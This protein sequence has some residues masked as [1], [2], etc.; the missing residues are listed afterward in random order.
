M[1][2]TPFWQAQRP[3]NPHGRLDAPY[4]RFDSDG[5]EPFFSHPIS[6]QAA[7]DPIRGSRHPW[8]IPDRPL[9][10]S[11]FPDYQ[12]APAPVETLWFDAFPARS[13]NPRFQGPF[14]GPRVLD[15]RIRDQIKR[16]KGKY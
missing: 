9:G 3:V 6:F 4:P 15:K 16:R 13:V 7:V 10:F 14:R 1:N 2:N 12:R 8:Q 11:G 5:F